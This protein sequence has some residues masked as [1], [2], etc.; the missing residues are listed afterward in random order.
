MRKHLGPQASTVVITS[1]GRRKENI[2]KDIEKRFRSRI[3]D[4]IGQVSSILIK[5]IVLVL[6]KIRQNLLILPTILRASK[7]SQAFNEDLRLLS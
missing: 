7:L 1:H 3:K 4:L 5:M 2:N 6:K